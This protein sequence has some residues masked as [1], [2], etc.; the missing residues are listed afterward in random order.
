MQVIFKSPLSLLQLAQLLGLASATNPRK[1]KTI[2]SISNASFVLLHKLLHTCICMVSSLNMTFSISFLKL[3]MFS[4]YTHL[5]NALF[6]NEN[7]AFFMM[8]LCWNCEFR[9]C[10][11]HMLLY[12]FKKEGRRERN[13]FI[14]VEWASFLLDWYFC[15]TA[16]KLGNSRSRS[17]SSAR[18]KFN[19]LENDHVWSETSTRQQEVTRDKVYMSSLSVC[20]QTC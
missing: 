5:K 8:F 3:N 10:A 1:C 14:R 4:R 2:P 6:I 13:D 15:G 7:C 9:V 16:K 20:F 18:N 12:F 11:T 17:S 19:K